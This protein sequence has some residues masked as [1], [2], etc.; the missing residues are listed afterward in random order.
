MLPSLDIPRV[1]AGPFWFG[2]D[3][4]A[5]EAQDNAVL[6]GDWRSWLR[7][8]FEG[9]TTHGFAPHHER[10]WDWVWALRRG[11]RPD[12]LVDAW[13]RGGAKS[14]SAELSCVAVGALDKRS[15]CLYISGTQDQADDHVQNVADMLAAPELAA[16]YPRLAE[17]KLGKYG[18][19]AGWR[20]NRLRTASG[21]TVDAAGLDK[22]FR[23]LKLEEKRPDFMVFDDVDSETDTAATTEKKIAAITRKALPA[24][25]RDLAVMVSQNLVIPDGVVSR[26]VDGRA[27]FLTGRLVNGP[28][29][30]VHDLA[31]EESAEGHVTL[32]GTPSWEGQDLE[33]CEAFVKDFGLDAFLAECQ[34]RMDVLGK[35]AFRR[36]WWEGKNRFDPADPRLARLCYGRFAALDTASKGEEDNAYTVCVVGEV[37]RDYRLRVVDVRRER[38]EFPDLPDWA[39][40]ALRPHAKDLKLKGVWV[41]D[42][43]SGTQLLQVLHRSGPAW[44]RRV[45]AASLPKGAKEERWAPAALHCRRGCVLLPHPATASWLPE[46]EEEL[47]ALNP[48]FKDQRDAFSLLVNMMEAAEDDGGMGGLL[49]A[50]WV[51]RRSTALRGA[52]A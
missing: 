32:S 31:Y 38:V 10:H 43:S 13:A 51:G 4:R 50:G 47:F 48:K 34:H 3:P 37:D 41:E 27:K 21:F 6:E 33:A 14:T 23:G 30:A 35:R 22:G 19:S 25:A 36:E 17:R 20:R 49:S 28:V 9:Y 42:A 8:L 52:R 45:L 16:R 15:Y 2:E 46:L 24:G 39:L 7:A 26:L 29:P 5:G 12:A 44:L 1:D 11:V 40:S 18:T